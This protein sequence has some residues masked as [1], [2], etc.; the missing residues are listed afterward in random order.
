ML[1]P[2]RLIQRPLKPSDKGPN[3]FSFGG[4][5]RYGGLAEDIAKLISRFFDFDYMG[6]AEFE[7]G[8]VPEA[9]ARLFG[10]AVENQLEVWE[11]E[12][13]PK[14][15]GV[16]APSFRE[17]KYRIKKGPLKMY[18]LAFRDW[19]EQVEERILEIVRGRI[20]LKEE[21]LF[22]RAYMEPVKGGDTDRLAGWFELNNAFMFFADPEMAKGVSE[23]LFKNGNP[24]QPKQ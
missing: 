5:R 3:P 9:L 11:F 10:W 23:V 14:A 24:L 12:L 6:R 17:E 20:S 13:P 22:F 7:Y 8:A 21:P 19:K 15:K 16:S 1:K 18:A 2:S 4:G